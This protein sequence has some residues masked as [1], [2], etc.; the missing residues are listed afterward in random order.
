MK[1]IEQLGLSQLP[2]T[3]GSINFP[4]GYPLDADRKEDGKWAE[5]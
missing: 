5:V 4:D 3:L 1:T 2:W